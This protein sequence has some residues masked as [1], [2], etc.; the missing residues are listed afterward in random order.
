MLLH[1]P[2]RGRFS[3][4][5]SHFWAPGRR[6]NRRKE[7]ANHYLWYQCAVCTASKCRLGPNI[8]NIT[9]NSHKACA[10]WGTEIQITGRAVSTEG[11]I[12]T[13]MKMR[14]TTS[15]KTWPGLG[16]DLVFVPL[17]LAFC[18]SDS[19][20]CWF[21]LFFVRLSALPGLHTLLSS[22]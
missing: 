4:K 19:G 14:N 3:A 11:L 1:K 10:R 18:D 6:A 17:G 9:Q 2:S 7:K 21:L 16:S 20:S 8:L 22:L 5:P 12:L 15:S 13:E